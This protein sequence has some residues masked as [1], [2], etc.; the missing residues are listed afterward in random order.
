MPNDSEI[1]LKRTAH[2][3]WSWSGHCRLVYV[4]SEWTGA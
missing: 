1:S 2:F 3:S 4:V